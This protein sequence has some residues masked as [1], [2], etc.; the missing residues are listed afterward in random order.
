MLGRISLAL[1]C[2]LACAAGPAAA[3]DNEDL[4]FD[5]TEDLYQVCMTKPDQPEYVATSF[6][7][8]AF[9]EATVQYH[10]EVSGRKR[11]KPLL[12]HPPTATVDD[13]RQAFMAWAEANKD[14]AKLMGEQ[15]VV[16]VVRA[17]AAKYP[18]R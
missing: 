16:G 5:T 11:M 15:P 1:A 17:L 4:N 12:C 9:I 8:R 13:G 10:D 2:A 6:A 3:V 14:N 18:C 7:C